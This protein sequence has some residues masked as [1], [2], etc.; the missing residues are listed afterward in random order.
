MNGSSHRVQTRWGD[1]DALGHVHHAAA[2]VFFEQGRDAFLGRCGISRSDYVVGR[3]DVTWMAEIRP[4]ASEV[5]VE[6]GVTELGSSS[7]TTAER[8][9]DE[10]GNV[11]VEGRFGL[12]LWDAR[13]R[14]PRPLTD[15]ER[16]ALSA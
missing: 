9:L 11:V 4:E 13:A 16:E 10:S 1:L 12:V 3:C 5:V 14:G 8:I 2:F 6:T 15:T 7:V